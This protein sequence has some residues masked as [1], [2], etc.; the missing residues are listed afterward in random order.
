MDETIA[1]MIQE[2]ERKA[3]YWPQVYYAIADT[4]AETHPAIL[5]TPMQEYIYANYC[6][7][8]KNLAWKFED[9]YFYVDL[10]DAT[11][12][13]KKYM[14][15]SLLYKSVADR[16]ENWAAKTDSMKRAAHLMNDWEKRPSLRDW[17][18]AMH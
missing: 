3:W 15:R 9:I 1:R 13:Y 17:W 14:T 8:R 11:S 16:A 4:L 5:D 18:I 10:W 6:S 2:G 12:D 7:H